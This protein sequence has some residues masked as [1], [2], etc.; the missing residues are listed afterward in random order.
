MDIHFRT[1]KL[2][3]LCNSQK[4]M[5]RKWNVPNAKKLQQRLYELQACANLAEMRMFPAAHCHS[6]HGD[7]AAEFAVDLQSTWRLIFVPDH[8]PIPCKADGSTDLIRITAITIT[9]VEDYHG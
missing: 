1:T 7:R 3:K 8:D 2:A 5:I 6:L 4:A 9:K